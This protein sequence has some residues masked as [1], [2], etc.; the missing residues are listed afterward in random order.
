VGEIIHQ[1]TAF[2]LAQVLMLFGTAALS[3][4]SIIWQSFF[5]L[6]CLGTATTMTRIA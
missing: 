3:Q 2:F 1:M 6:V 5:V 4:W